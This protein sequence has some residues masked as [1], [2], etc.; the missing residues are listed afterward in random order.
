MKRIYL[1]MM[2]LLPLLQ[3]TVIFA[4]NDGG[5]KI[6][7]TPS[8]GNTDDP[9]GLSE[10]STLFLA[11][12]NSGTLTITTENYAGN[13]T[14]LLMG[15]PGHTLLHESDEYISPSSS[16]NINTSPLPTGTYTIIVF[17]G[18]EIYSGEIELE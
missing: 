8:T 17:V 5:D 6:I 7:L 16:V 1:L 15:S 12:C 3:G 2:L 4:G 10:S 14:V 13:A 9:T 11:E 18:N